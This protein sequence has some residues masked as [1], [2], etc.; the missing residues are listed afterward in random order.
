MNDTK[1]T[2]LEPADV[3]FI[4]HGAT[5]EADH[6][7]GSDWGRCGEPAQAIISHDGR[8]RYVCGSHKTRWRQVSSGE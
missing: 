8:D 5:C 3:E 7:N 2:G 6:D 4:P 1:R